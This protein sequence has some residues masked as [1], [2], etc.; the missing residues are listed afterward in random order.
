MLRKYKNYFVLKQ[1]YYAVVNHPTPSNLT[2]AWNFG[3]LAFLCLMIQFVTGI[4]LA[5]HYIPHIS[6]AFAS[7]EHI[8]RDVHGGWLIRYAHAN[9]ASMFFIV[10]YVHI[11]RGL[12]YTS[13]TWPRQAV[14]VLGVVLLL[15]MIMTAFMGYVLPWG[16]MSFWGATVITNLFS[17]VPVVGQDLVVWLWGNHSVAGSTLTRFYALHFVLPFVIL[18][19]AVI[20]VIVL[21]YFGSNNPLG[22][23]FMVDAIPFTP[24]YL[25]KDLFGFSLFFG[26]FG[27]FLFFAPNLLNHPD[28]YIPANSTVTPPHIVPEWYFLPFY[29]VLRSVPNKIGGVLLML[30]AIVVLFFLPFI[31]RAEIRSFQFRTFSRYWFWAMVGVCVMLGWLGGQPAAA[32]YV[33]LSACLTGTY[34]GMLLV[35]LPV[36]ESFE[37]RLIFKWRSV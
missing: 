30:S 8:M 28:N 16:Q 32:P 17:A 35:V 33:E 10:V 36:L 5:M 19:V 9:G 3:S 23:H 18:G 4:S 1:L 26:F 14:W 37:N 29:A 2:Y 7:V 20:H 15:L 6:M 25:L 21:Q 13:Y 12:Y 34:F 11:F 24:Y 22:V 31:S 27:L